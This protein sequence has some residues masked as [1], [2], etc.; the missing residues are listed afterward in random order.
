[1]DYVTDE[2]DKSCEFSTHVRLCPNSCRNAT[3]MAAAIREAS[4]HSDNDDND[5]EVKADTSLT[6]SIRLRALVRDAIATLH[7]TCALGGSAAV[8]A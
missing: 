6:P 7:H 4:G 2:L 8:C 3:S 5:D 1:M